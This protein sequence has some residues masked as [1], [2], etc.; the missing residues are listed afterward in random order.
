MENKTFDRLMKGF[1]TILAIVAC[2]VVVF[3][4]VT[5]IPGGT[6]GKLQLG[7]IEISDSNGSVDIYMAISY[8]TLD[9]KN[10]LKNMLFSSERKAAKIK[11]Q[12][13]LFAVVGGELLSYYSDA[14]VQ[15]EPSPN[16]DEFIVTIKRK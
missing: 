5:M 15:I 12:N 11:Y 9:M 4:V 1:V 7:S 14:I 6:G 2:V 10:T 13:P 16:E 3:V 8:P